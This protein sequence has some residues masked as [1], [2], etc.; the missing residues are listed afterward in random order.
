MPFWAY[1]LHCADRTFYVGHTDD[2]EKRVGEHGRDHVA[3]RDREPDCLLARGLD[4]PGVPLGPALPVELRDDLL[5]RAGLAVELPRRHRLDRVGHGDDPRPQGDVLGGETVGVAVAV[6]PLVVVADDRSCARE[7]VERLQQL[8][9]DQRMLFR[10][11]PLLVVQRA[12]RGVM[13]ADELLRGFAIP[14]GTRL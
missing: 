13:S 6:P 11:Q 1:M 7:Q 9:A 14:P 8:V 10:D 4:D 12:G 3:V 5:G 2:L